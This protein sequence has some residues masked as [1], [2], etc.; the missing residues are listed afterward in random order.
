MAFFTP[1]RRI[2]FFLVLGAL[3]VA[4]LPG[5]VVKLNPA[6]QKSLLNVQFSLPQ[7]SPER[8][9]YSLTSVLENA[10]SQISGI[11]EMQSVSRYHGG[12]ITLYFDSDA[13]MD[14]KQFEAS[15]IIRGLYP[16]LPEEASYPL[17]TR[18]EEEEMSQRPLLVAL[19]SF[20]L[21]AL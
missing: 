21:N 18:V 10:L 2:I 8:V 19:I 4:C 1:F 16:Q 3:G 20:K 14:Q 12:S 17:I 5:L 13:P 6:R 7:A 11:K 9:E 15:T